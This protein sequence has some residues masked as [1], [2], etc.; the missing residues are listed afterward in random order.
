MRKIIFSIFSLLFLFSCQ[1][2]EDAPKS[3]APNPVV[4]DWGYYVNGKLEANSRGIFARINA[5]G[6]FTFHYTYVDATGSRLYLRKSIGIY[7]KKSD[8]LYDVKYSYETCNAVGSETLSIKIINDRLVVKTASGAL[9]LMDKLTVNAYENLSF[10]GTEDK[11]CDKFVK[12]ESKKDRLPA[13]ELNN[14]FFKF[15]KK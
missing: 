7:V 11:G 12:L 8:D 13:N 10:A 6:S 3:E 15:W 1:K 14:S 4:G 5:D 9:I 2:S